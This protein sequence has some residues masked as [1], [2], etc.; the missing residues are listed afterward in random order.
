[1]VI[2]NF[3]VIEDMEIIFPHTQADTNFSKNVSNI[4]SSGN[5][6]WLM[7]LGENGV[8]KSSFLQA[9][10][11]S[12]MGSKYLDKLDIR[13]KDILRRGAEKGFVKIYTTGSDVPIGI[14]FSKRSAKIMSTHTTPQ[15][16][17]LAYGSTRLLVGKK[18]KPEPN[19]VTRNIRA[20]NLFDPSYALYGNQWLVSLYKTNREQFDYAARAIMDILSEELDDP[21][22][23]L[24]V[25]KGEVIVTHTHRPPDKMKELSD[26]YKSIIATACDMMS[27]LL[28]AGTMESAEG[29]VVIDEI[30][31]HL[32]PRWCM[33]VV[34]SFRKTFPHMQ[35]IATTHDPLCLRGL[36][37][38]E[39][40]IFRKDKEAHKISAITDLPDPSRMRVDQLLTSEFFGLNS[41]IDPAEEKMLN[42]YHYLLS[43]ARPTSKQKKR[44]GELETALKP[45]QEL[46]NTWREELLYKAVDEV[47]AMNK[48]KMPGQYKGVQKYE[49]NE[50]SEEL[51]VNDSG[52]E[53]RIKSD[54]FRKQA[55]AEVRARIREVWD[56]N[57]KQ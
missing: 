21:E 17:L 12:L 10:V 54:D 15:G 4:N 19:A 18:L 50:T 1:M 27:L 55:E 44:I 47:V 28:R 41:V 38:N 42:E 6:N 30:G 34:E 56:K 26:G 45:Y 49:T 43:R 20:M 36:Q 51:I 39:V 23:M 22:A 31:T 48:L 46:G 9:I 16:Y 11:L 3:R 37:K 24:K 13:A 14:E 25:E 7:L 8:G 5:N 53:Y 52:A 2:N 35:F 40:V 29:L 33:R 32:H 57:T